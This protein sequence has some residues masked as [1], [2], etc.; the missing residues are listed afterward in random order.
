MKKEK[1]EQRENKR[2]LSCLQVQN[3]KRKK[4]K[5][6]KWKVMEGEEKVSGKPTGRDKRGCKWSPDNAR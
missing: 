5:K 3:F 1:N 6:K 4:E 2:T